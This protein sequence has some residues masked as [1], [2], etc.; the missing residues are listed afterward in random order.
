MTPQF[1]RLLHRWI[2]FFR[3]AKLYS[4]F[5]ALAATLTAT[6]FLFR[7]HPPLTMDDWQMIARS[8]PVWIGQELWVYGGEI[9]TPYLVTVGGCILG[10]VVAFVEQSYLER[11]LRESERVK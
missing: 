11:Q 9:V 6:D 8:L 10:W 4:F 5:M 2:I 3:L 1:E 7:V